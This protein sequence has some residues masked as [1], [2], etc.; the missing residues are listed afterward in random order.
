MEVT[1]PV[2]DFSGRISIEIEVQQ[3]TRILLNEIGDFLLSQRI[4]VNTEV[5]Q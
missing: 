2:N 3:Q 4:I 1:S 5:I